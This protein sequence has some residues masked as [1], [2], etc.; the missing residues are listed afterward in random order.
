MKDAAAALFSEFIAMKLFAFT[1]C[2][3][4]YCGMHMPPEA[5]KLPA[6]I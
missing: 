2:I 6:G 1:F 4:I 3:C 5:N